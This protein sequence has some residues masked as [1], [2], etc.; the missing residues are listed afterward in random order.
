MKPA[1][2][3]LFLGSGTSVGVPVIGC[4]CAVCQSLDPKNKRFR[5]SVLVSHDEKNILID[6]T[7]DLRSQALTFGVT[8]VD[9]V[10]LTHTHADHLNG[11]DDLRQF[12]NRQGEYLSLYG[13]AEHIAH[14][15]ETFA[16]AFVE[17]RT[18]PGFPRLRAEV[19]NG[20]L[21]L[22]GLTVTPLEVHH[23]QWKVTSF[24]FEDGDGHRIAYV[25]DVNHIPASTMA[26]LTDLDLLILDALRYR[27]HPV[28]FSVA[29]AL[30][31]VEQL[32]PR[33]TY[34][35]HICHELDH[36]TVNAELPPHVQLAYDGL[37]VGF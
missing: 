16:Y 1:L 8:Q 13:R 27:P 3:V 30:E 10:L 2:Q 25:T 31:V 20:T 9:A 5:P 6:T 26:E 32:N 36:R 15:T 7:P 11:L 35:T 14:V 12:T 19:L 22:F 29:Q 23:G 21:N 18:F 34:F 33:Q 37:T 17:G 4:A 24:R 28:H